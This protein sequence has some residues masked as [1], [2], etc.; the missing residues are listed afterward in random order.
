MRLGLPQSYKG[1]PSRAASAANADFVI[2]QMFAAV[3]SGQATPQQA[4]KEAQ[5]RAERYFRKA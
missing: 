1:R 5:R 2:P 3:C 4:A